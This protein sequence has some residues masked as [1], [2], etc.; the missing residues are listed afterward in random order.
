MHIGNIDALFE[1]GTLHDQIKSSHNETTPYLTNIKNR[2]KLPTN[3]HTLVF[4]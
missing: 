1:N 3:D 2:F 4:W